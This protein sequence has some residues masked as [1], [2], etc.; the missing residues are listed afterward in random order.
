MN[1]FT[2]I[3]ANLLSSLVSR[4]GGRAGARA[5]RRGGAWPGT[6]GLGSLPTRGDAGS[7]ASRGLPPSVWVGLGM[8]PPATALGEPSWQPQTH[9]RGSPVARPEPVRRI[10]PPP[11]PPPSRPGHRNGRRQAET[12]ELTLLVGFLFSNCRFKVYN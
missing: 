4:A 8:G 3:E 11:P 6:R 2:F 12:T 9:H 1:E 5:A 7:P 10:L